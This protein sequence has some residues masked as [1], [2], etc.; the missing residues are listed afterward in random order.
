MR[1]IEKLHDIHRCALTGGFLKELRGRCG[2]LKL[3]ESFLAELFQSLPMSGACHRNVFLQSDLAEFAAPLLRQKFTIYPAEHEE[4]RRVLSLFSIRQ[5]LQ[6]ETILLSQ[7]ENDFGTLLE[8]LEKT[9]VYVLSL[10][11]CPRALAPWASR[12]IDLTPHILEFL[13]R[14]SEETVAMQPPSAMKEIPTS[15]QVSLENVDSLL[16]GLT[17]NCTSKEKK[18]AETMPVVSLEER[19]TRLQSSMRD[20]AGKFKNRSEECLVRQKKIQDGE[21]IRQKE[22][23]SFELFKLL[24][25]VEKCQK[26][27]QWFSELHRLFLYMAEDVVNCR[28][29]EQELTLCKNLKMLSTGM[30]RFRHFNDAYGDRFL[31]ECRGFLQDQVASLLRQSLP[32]FKSTDPIPDNKSSQRVKDY[33]ERRYQKYCEDMDFHRLEASL[34]EFEED[35]QDAPLQAVLDALVNLFEKHSIKPNHPR[36]RN[37]FLPVMEKFPE[38]QN[39]PAEFYETCQAVTVWQNEQAE[40]MELS[41]PNE[42]EGYE[43]DENI[44]KVR[45]YLRGKSIVL[46]GG[47]PMP[48]LMERVE[49]AFHCN[50]L[51]NKT[52]HGESLDRYQSLV[53]NPEV[54]LFVVFVKW[55]S[56]KH[57]EELCQMILKRGKKVARL[58]TET[59]PR[60]IAKKIV[61]MCL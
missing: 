47:Q 37:L 48:H 14:R 53:R 54:G 43:E 24:N 32:F 15:E 51:W 20:W 26:A 39:Y 35:S 29:K 50:V 44:Q 12:W 19:L 10:S 7:G 6:G 38:E 23:S 41:F 25:T 34:K 49:R 22:N 13:S 40:K 27:S 33:V 31:I 46:I 30:A 56:H 42:A 18:R 5:E 16:S 2:N 61:S 55:A 8:S 17:K 3:Q 11:P 52:S 9:E 36:L 59:N 28:T 60:T 21:F 45:E 4:L 57:S 58:H 1:S